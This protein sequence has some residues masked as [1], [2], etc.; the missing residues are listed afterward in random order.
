M[1][2]SE[3]IVTIPNNIFYL[4][5]EQRKSIWKLECILNEN[6]KLDLSDM[7]EPQSSG[8]NAYKKLSRKEVIERF[9]KVHKNKYGY[10]DMIYKNAVKPIQVLCPEHGLFFIAANSHWRGSGCPKCRK[11]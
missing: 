1:H 2:N 7:E 4:K 3:D 6:E 8:R 9:R 11:K 5:R 10:K